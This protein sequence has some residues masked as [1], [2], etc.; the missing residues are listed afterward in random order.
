VEREAALRKR[1]EQLSPEQRAAL[2]LDIARRRE[3][4]AQSAG[5]SE[6]AGQAPSA[7]RYPLSQA[8][9]RLWMLAQMG[10]AANAAYNI[11]AAFCFDAA[12]DPE[13]LLGAWRR[14]LADHEVLRSAFVHDG[15][16]LFQMPR[17]PATWE[18]ERRTLAPERDTETQLAQ[19]AQH[20]ATKPFDLQ[21]DWLLRVIYCAPPA[22]QA[23]RA[24]LI[25]VIHHIVCDGLS[26]AGM[27]QELA[28]HYQGAASAPAASTALQ[29]R[30]YVAYEAQMDTAKALA[31]WKDL[32]ASA[33]ETLDALLDLPRP[34]AKDFRGSSVSLVL[35]PAEVAAFETLCHAHK[36]TLYMGLVALAQVVLAR[37]A[38]VDEVVL[39]T[40]VAGRPN[41]RFGTVVGPFVNTVALRQNIDRAS[42]FTELLQQVKRRVLEGFEH[43]G[44]AFDALVTELG[45]AK[46][47]SRSP[48][49][50]VMLGFTAADAM[51]LAFGES[52][53]RPVRLPLAY[54]KVDLT[55]HLER[56]RDGS[57]RLELEY[58]TALLRAATAQR[59]ARAWRLLFLA[60]PGAPERALGEFPLQTAEE[61]RALLE[62]VNATARPYPQ[63]ASLVGEFRKVVQA[64]PDADAVHAGNVRL[65]YRELD[66]Q[67]ER[68]AAWLL[69]HPAHQPGCHVALMLEKDARALVVILGILKSGS[70]YVPIAADA[71]LDRVRHIVE[72]GAVRLLFAEVEVAHSAQLGDVDVALIDTDALL[73]DDDEAATPAPL[74]R[75]SAAEAAQAAATPAYLMF[76]SGSTGT[77]KGTLIE[78]QSVLRLVCNT[79]Y[80]QVKVHERVLLTGSLAFDAAT[81]EIWGALLNG[82]CVCIPPGTTLLEV[83]DFQAL[84]FD[85]RVD[86]VFLTTGLFNQLVDHSVQAFAALHTVLTGGEKI[87]VEHVGKLLRAHP[88]LTVLHVYGPTE[89][90][91]FS[92]W[93]RIDADDLTAST[94]PI[95]RP[96]ANSRLYLLDRHMQPVPIGVP[97]EIYCGGDGVARGYVAQHASAKTEASSVFMPDP[98]LPS[99]TGR[100]Y[101]TG[102]LAKWNEQ[103]E[104]VFLGRNDRQVKIRGFRVELGEVEYHLRAL[105]GIADAFVQARGTAGSSELIA[106]LVAP[107]GSYD[108]VA[109]RAALQ[110]IVPQYMMPA[111]VVCVERLPLNASGKVDARALPLPEATEAAAAP[112]A[113]QPQGKAEQD[114]AQLYASVLGLAENGAL[115]IDRNANFFALGGDSIRAIQLVARAR[116]AGYHFTVKDM[117]ASDT[118]AGLAASA[119]TLAVA[120]PAALLQRGP[121]SPTQRWWLEQVG[122]PADHFNLSSVF[123]IAAAVDMM[124]LREALDALCEL[125]PALRLALDTDAQQQY[126]RAKADYV[127]RVSADGQPRAQLWSELQQAIDLQAGILLAVGVAPVG[128]ATYL[129]VVVHHLAADEVSGR[130]FAANLERL[131]HQSL[132]RRS[133]AVPALEPLRESCGLIDWAAQL[134][135]LVQQGGMDRDLDYWTDVVARGREVRARQG[136]LFA[137]RS[138]RDEAVHTLSSDTTRTLLRL[139]HDLLRLRPQELLLAA[140][141][142]AWQR[143]LHEDACLLS[144]EG[145]GRE[146]YAEL[147]DCSATLGWFTSLYPFVIDATELQG[148]DLYRAIKDRVRQV[149]AKGFTYLPLRYYK[150]AQVQQALTLRPLLSFNYLGETAPEAEAWLQATHEQAGADHGADVSE[151]FALDVLTRI[152]DGQLELTLRGRAP[153]E[154]VPVT[155]LNR[156]WAAELASLA[157]TLQD[158]AADNNSD[159]TVLS[160][161]DCL[162]PFPSLAVLDATLAALRLRATDIEEILPL[163]GMQSGLWLQCASHPTAYRDQV[164]LRLRQP[165]DASRFAA[166]VRA[167]V[168]ETQALRTGFAQAPNGEL[169]QIVFRDRTGNYRYV[170]AAAWGD[171]TDAELERLR[172]RLRDWSRDL[173]RAPLFNLTLVRIDAA[174]FELIIDFHHLAIDGWTS[175]L[176]LARL[177][178]LYRDGADSGRAASGMRA[179]FQWLGAQSTAQ[180]RAYWHALLGDYHSRIDVPAHLPR[181]PAATPAPLFVETR[182]GSELHAALLTWC[183]RQGLTLNAAVQALWGV[184]L[185]RQCGSDNLVFGATVSGRDGDL[186]GVERIAG[187]LINTLP[188]RI[189]LGA[190]AS[191]ADL[192]RATAQQFAESLSFGHLPLA[193]I[194]SLAPARAGLITHTLVFENYPAAKATAAGWQWE[195]QAI[196]DPMHF[197][198]GVIVAPLTNDISFRFVADGSLYLPDKLERMGAELSAL[199][200]TLLSAEQPLDEVVFAA[201]VARGWSVSANFTA[202]SLVGLLQYHEYICGGSSDVT[203]LPYDQSI[204]ELLDPRSRLRRLKARHHVVLWRPVTDAAGTLLESAASEQL[205]QLAEAMA[206]YARACKGSRLYFVP[207]PWPDCDWRQYREFAAYAKGALAG[208]RNAEVLNLEMLAAD[209][210]LEQPCHPPALVFGDIPYTEDFFAALANTL[211]RLRDLQA[212][213]PVKVYVVDADDTLWGGIVGEDGVQGIRL[214]AVHLQLQQ[215]LLK[216]RAAGALLCVVTKN[217]DDDVRAVFEQREMPLRW[218]HLTRVCAG[219]GPKSDSILGL[220]RELALGLDSFVFIDDSPLECA[221]VLDACPGVLAIQLPTAP[222]RAAF[223]RHLWLLD[224]RAATR[225]DAARAQMYAEE[226][227]RADARKATGS[228]AEFLASLDIQVDMQVLTHGDLPRVAQLS[229]RTNQFNTRGIRYTEAELETLL[230]T[231]G[232]DIRCVRVRD[233]YGDYGLVGSVFVSRGAQAWTVFGF[234]L[235]CRVL[236]RG[237]E[238]A[239]LRE[240]AREAAAS[241]AA[242]LSVDFAKLARNAPALQFLQSLPGVIAVAATGTQDAV[243]QFLLPVDAAARWQPGHDDAVPEADADAPVAKN[244]APVATATDKQLS[245]RTSGYYAY[246]AGTL[247]SGAAILHAL[248]RQGLVQTTASAR[249][250]T[251]RT[252]PGTATETTL[253]QFFCELLGV[254]EVSRED[255]FHDLGGHSLKAMMLLARIAARFGIS[256]DFNDLQ[257]N[258]D[259]GTLAARI[260]EALAGADPALAAGLPVLTALPEADSYPAAPGQKRLWM[261]EQIRA[262]GPSPFHMHATLTVA[263]RIDRQALERALHLLCARHEALRTCFSEDASGRIRQSVLPIDSVDIGVQWFD[264]VLQDVEL[265]TY[266]QAHQQL[267]FDLGRAPLMRLA[268]GELASGGTALFLTMHHIVSDGWSIGIFARELSSL[269]RVCTGDAARADL[270]PAS[271]IQFRDFAAWQLAWLTSAAGKR[272][273]DFWREHFATPVEVLQLPAHAPRPAL[274]QSAGATISST[275][276]AEVWSGFKRQLAEMG[277]SEFSGLFAALQLVLARLSGQRDFCIGTAVAGRQHPQLEAV[278][279][280]FVNLVPLRTTLD[281]D[282][283]VDAFLRAVAREVNACLSHQGIPFDRIISGLDLARDPGRTPLFDVLLVLQNAEMSELQFGADVAT[284]H[285]VPSATSQ[286]DLTVSAYP[287]ADGTLQLVAEY[288]GHYTKANIALLLRCVERVMQGLA[289][290]RSVT[291]AQVPWLQDDDIA[292][293][294]AFEGALLEQTPELLPDLFR[295]VVPGAGGRIGD[296]ESDWS[297]TELQQEMERIARV[298]RSRRIGTSARKQAH[299]GVIGKRSV[300]SVAAMLGAMDAGAVYVPLDLANPVDRLL[301]IIAE[302]AVEVLLSTD[303]DGAALATALQQQ[304]AGLIHV[305]YDDV[306]DADPVD[307]APAEK[308]RTDTGA[309][310]YMI[311]TSGSTGKPKG[312]QISHAAFA[313]MI[314]QQIPAFDVRTGDVCA[315]FASLSFDASLSEIFLALGTGASL[316]IAPDDAR[317][318]ID[319][320]MHWLYAKAVTVITLPP[321]FLRA[322]DQRA[323]GN[324]RV[325]ITAGEAAIGADLRH[326]AASLR[327]LNAYGPTETSVCASIYRVDARDAWPFGVPIGAPLPGVLLTVRDAAGARVPVGV[328][329]ELYI[330]GASLGAGYYGA[331]ELTA[332]KF[333]AIPGDPQPRRW[334]RSG[335][336]V[337]WRDDGLLEFLG[338][339]D[340]QVKVR[341]YRIEPG[342]IEHAARRIAGVNDAVA[343]V[344]EH[345]GLLLYCVGERAQDDADASAFRSRILDALGA[346]L[347][348]HMLPGDVLLVDA[349]PL[350]TAGKI[351]RG[352]LLAL[353]ST[354]EAPFAPPETEAEQAL[355]QAWRQAL[356]AERVGRHDDFFALGGDSIKALTVLSALRTLGFTCGLKDFFVAPRLQDM[357]RSLTPYRD[358]GGFREALTGPIDLLPV[359]DW[360]LRSRSA[361]AARHFHIA[362][363]LRVATAVSETLLRDVLSLLVE[364]HDSLRARFYL[365]DGRWVQDIQQALDIDAVL[366]PYQRLDAHEEQSERAAISALACKPFVLETGP[367]FRVVLV[368]GVD[369]RSEAV[370]LVLHHLIA[371]WVSLRILV[372][373]LNALAQSLADGEE[374]QTACPP[375]PHLLQV[376]A[377]ARAAEA[378]SELS[379][380]PGAVA[381][382]DE[383]RQAAATMAALAFDCGVHSELQTLHLHLAPD[384]LAGLR[385][386]LRRAS[387]GQ[388]VEFRLQD[389]ILATAMSELADLFA[390]DSVPILVESHGRDGTLDLTQQVAWLTRARLHHLAPSA[391]KGP[392]ALSQANRVLQPHAASQPDVFA[393]IV[394]EQILPRGLPALLSFN[395]LGSFVAS[396]KVKDS[397]QLTDTVFDK[398]LAPESPVDVPL[399]IEFYIVNEAL[400]IQVAWS[401]AVFESGAMRSCWDRVRRKLADF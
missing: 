399:H 325:L 5:H 242:T 16:A 112:G 91:T 304:Q 107:T 332:Q 311:F 115:A 37:M 157:A 364:N 172:T 294:A 349:F 44:L 308:A 216:A 64:Y 229:Q 253:A 72:A 141:V 320:F 378:A 330:G 375:P 194:Q 161:S 102:D 82:G 301:T 196:F 340:D 231:P 32:F 202:D 148:L 249:A 86:T 109:L 283:T 235:S 390:L 321:V 281:F 302:G 59:L 274:M 53:G 147:G 181:M 30:D 77:P 273:A 167:L 189:D 334:Y 111:K 292:A 78:Q 218:T 61:R 116:A 151:P 169:L 367:L 381:A 244:Q 210:A 31:Y 254:A 343:L 162:V 368:R 238:H 127:L 89:N 48:L 267:A 142:R 67:S 358:A 184:F 43:Q 94:V 288:A 396:G 272:A 373:D 361:E 351:A 54:S 260:E 33:P 215:S 1:L 173:L 221:Q 324:L 182:I 154:T 197:E 131:Y 204:Q 198:F 180:A 138:A 26:I 140:F 345:L 4:A 262:D 79:D 18:M 319:T 246:M 101:R 119:G 40:P 322:L 70:V 386:S 120:A 208:L 7:S 326:Y 359:Q 352:A 276:A 27:I 269:Y 389:L 87:S 143:T 282:G 124:A 10:D 103:R 385:A 132:A 236:G 183:G 36:A 298:L 285:P 41:A 316:A 100:L 353:A 158:I 106:W 394:T 257:A 108:V 187:M 327:V 113:Q 177:E 155:A 376:L 397:L 55:F 370:V 52:H 15:D 226:L 271:A 291:V 35:E 354:R 377:H 99:G 17:A 365:R 6:S 13:R 96:I 346:T 241:G 38:N 98:F 133:G 199:L 51:A 63:Q 268:A 104:L 21:Q 163:T 134:A 80:H 190:N 135:T 237:V 66:A 374:V 25:V 228:Y 110:G 314:R 105:P 372:A 379:S 125:H 191:F 34:V 387:T 355:A 122:K 130:V 299:V 93:H 250:A 92:S 366:C 139:G 84:V 95:G 145:H 57:L 259:I 47:P 166:A 85:Y 137:E 339:A 277:I 136:D 256:L 207:C 175:A 129:A 337:R 270:P 300:R 68:V 211:A 214:D 261:L 251:T 75:A 342:E 297:Y 193:E 318:D 201:D 176:L 150:G 118:L 383:Y 313:A 362:V 328:T 382:L 178:S 398:A 45:F 247:Q 266:A 19:L 62:D 179:Y 223:L 395:Y 205:A 233:K 209:Y 400:E 28:R 117:F 347:P 22:G 192:A 329:G 123:R 252:P 8:Q 56:E 81:F 305:R 20:E 360:F 293:V 289:N 220:A 338:R 12:L 286:Y 29:Y 212:R 185:A 341:G 317:S 307:T 152:A 275:V 168:A 315:Q 232:N 280:F 258:P 248:R 357:A 146:T 255:A 401:P 83:H 245:G 23:G 203:L 240:L 336:L 333:S 195:P 164:A 371:D 170:D 11:A 128:A 227:Q 2:L 156:A 188:V 24:G 264:P 149:P 225:E 344:H 234:M 230:R 369:G 42:S 165:L 46:D 290:S 380:E 356:N 287:A 65:S 174:C 69:S 239:L 144:L 153:R 39:G 60:L 50:D 88:A 76:T 171:A 160:L 219:W 3:Q 310:A 222:E 303:D 392:E 279:G 284:V 217:N 213:R 391:F 323:L 126:L 114:L 186:P 331:P 71:P 296:S 393:C 206:T 200:G 224:A 363:E 335:D 278:I 306:A 384:A 243:S 309:I 263:G 73:R 14:L 74:P 265:D 348:R 350:S 159:A 312:V 58:A 90:T 97:G 9:R 121:M 388:A 49:Y 295:R